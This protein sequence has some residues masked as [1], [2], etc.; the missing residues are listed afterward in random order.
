MKNANAARTA[1]SPYYACQWFEIEASAYYFMLDMLPPLFLRAGMF[2]MSEF[3]AGYI[4]SV[5]FEITIRGRRRWFT[6]FCD[7]SDRQSPDAMR[8]AI[9]AYESQFPDSMTREEK[10]EAI[11]GGTHPD[12]RGIAGSADPSAWPAEHR[13]KRS[14]LVNAGGHGTILKLLEDLTDEE[15]EDKLRTGKPSTGA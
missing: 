8:E 6:G 5:F 13:G 1:P 11:W 10:L 3:K 12:F 14:I 2:G 9:I 7:L 15:I 4:T